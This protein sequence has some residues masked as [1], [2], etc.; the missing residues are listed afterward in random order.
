MIPHARLYDAILAEHLEKHRQMAFVAGPR[1]VGKTTT[2][3]GL[4]EVYLDWDNQDDKRTILEGPAAVAKR[5]G[6]QRLR[7]APV[8][9]V[10]DELH[11]HGR[12]KTFLKGFFDTYGEQVR[13][14]VTGS[15]RLDLYRRGGDSLMGRYFLFRMHPLSVAEVIRQGL[16]EE[17]I[18]SPASLPEA[19]FSALWEH[20]GYPEPFFKRDGRFTRRWLSMRQ[21]LLLKE[22]VRDLTR[23]QDLG[24]MEMMGILLSERSGQQV[25]YSNLAQA[26]RV[27]VDTARRW[28]NALC[29]LHVGFLVR[30]WFVNVARSLR[31]EPK[32]FLR[33]WSGIVDP[34]ARAETFVA[35]HLLKAVEGWTDLG[36]G[37]FELR[38]LRDLQKNE[39]DFL[40]VRD[41]KPWFL[42]EVKSRETV[43]SPALGYFQRQTRAPHAF[44]VVL[45][46]DYVETDCFRRREPVVVPARTFLSQLL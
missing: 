39:A 40:I 30:P 32:W 37:A 44:Q 35:C 17:P 38:Y 41:R 1:Q 15:S 18:Q 12:W 43:L 46:M 26:V 42:V 19:K 27:S 3:Q 21:A 14:L 24:Q 6:L 23:I 16:P 45:E 28:V 7:E 8:V 33:D 5:L 22:D 31:K 4:G 11:K 13:L 10:F 29:S 34:G 25:I 20:G 36:L 9:A 2:C